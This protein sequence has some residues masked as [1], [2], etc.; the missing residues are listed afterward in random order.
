M[1]TRFIIRRITTP[2]K[3]GSDAIFSRQLHPEAPIGGDAIVFPL[4]Y[5]STTSYTFVQSV[6]IAQGKIHSILKAEFSTTEN[7]ELFM[8]QENLHFSFTSTIPISEQTDYEAKKV[9][10]KSE[11]LLHANKALHEFLNQKIPM[12]GEI[13]ECV[14]KED[15]HLLV[16]IDIK[17]PIELFGIKNQLNTIFG[18][19]YIR[20]PEHETKQILASVIAVV[21]YQRLSSTGRDKINEELK[22]LHTDLK[23]IGAMQ[24]LQVEWIHYRVRSLAMRYRLSEEAF[25]RINTAEIHPA[26][27]RYRKF[28]KTD[29]LKNKV[30]DEKNSIH[31][32]AL[33]QPKPPIFS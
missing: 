5:G 25:Q 1:D 27:F 32:A 31:P 12:T 19:T 24:F 8:M 23:K 3:N 7:N 21:D 26:A 33:P 28:S 30:T 11:Q 9:V 15:G 4:E 13:F 29:S 18:A 6:R 22:N 17:P 20:H 10:Q 16:R 14:M 2:P